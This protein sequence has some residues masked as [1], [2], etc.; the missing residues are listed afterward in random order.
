MTTDEQQRIH[1]M[2]DI[3]ASQ[4]KALIGESANLIAYAHGDYFAL[5][6]RIGDFGF[7]VRKKK[8]PPKK[9]PKRK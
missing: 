9:R 1:R 7:S 2:S 6:K 4:V 8:T 5:G 3:L